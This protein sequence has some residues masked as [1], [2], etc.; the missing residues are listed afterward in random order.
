MP[1]YAPPAPMPQPAAPAGVPPFPPAGA[2]AAV[3]EQYAALSDADKA[4]VWAAAGPQSAAPTGNP[5]AQ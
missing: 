2:W 1:Q 4:A 5:F 3:P